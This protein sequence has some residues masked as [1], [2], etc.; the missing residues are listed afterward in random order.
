MPQ[1]ELNELFPV[2]DRHIWLNHAAIS[3]WP[4]PVIEALSAFVEENSSLGAS[5]YDQWMETEDSLRVS[6]KRLLNAD[7]VDDITLLRNTSEGLNIIAQGIQ[8]TEGD[9]IVVFHNEFPSNLLP[10]LWLRNQGVEVRE[11]HCRTPEATESLIS[12][13]SNQTKLV[14]VSSVQ[15]DTGIRIDLK[16]LGEA[17]QQHGAL[18]C[19]DAIQHLG[20]LPLDVSKLA[21]DFVVCGSHKWLMAPE[22]LGLMWSK[23]SVRSQLTVALPGWRMYEDPFDFNRTD[24]QPPRSGK[25]FETGTINMFGVH[26]LLASIDLLN[27][28]NP[29]ETG[30][31]LLARTQHIIDRLNHFSQVQLITP[32]PQDQHAGIVAFSIEDVDLKSVVEKLHSQEIYVAK[33]GDALRLSPHF[34]TP[35]AQID[36]A[37]NCLEQALC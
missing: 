3:A 6:I 37:L 10:W 15:F 12:A 2:I 17:C 18:L 31:A 21:V 34:Y 22:G 23:P 4:K 7:S 29:D 19:V 16:R 1:L 32:K 8:W 30:L 9:E 24:W 35:I 5:Q 14:A 20:A 25:R 36:H 27:S 11:V 33:R 13:L 28:L 26:G